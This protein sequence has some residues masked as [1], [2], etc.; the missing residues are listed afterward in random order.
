M[1]KST[2]GG[3]EKGA[4]RADMLKYLKSKKKVMNKIAKEEAPAGYTTTE[5]IIKAF[6]LKPKRQAVTQAKLTRINS[7]LDKNGVMYVSFN[8]VC[9]GNTGKGQTPGKYIGLEAKGNRTEEQAYKDLYFTL[10]KCGFD[11]DEL[12]DEEA[13]L[14]FI[15]EFNSTDSSEKPIVSITLKCYQGTKG[16][17]VDVQVNKLLEDFEPEDSEE[18]E[19]EEEEK[20]KK[21]KGKKPSK[22]EEEEEKDDDS[23]D[24]DEEEEE[25]EEEEKPAKK[26]KGKK[27]EEPEEEEDDVEYDDT[28]PSTWV[29]YECKAQPKGTTKKA[30]Y[31]IVEFIKRGSKLK[32][33]NSKDEEYIVASDSVEVL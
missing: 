13:L 9:V 12:G 2:K 7:G 5:D 31:E 24:D 1:K 25:D 8:F 3:S 18:E 4:S 19:E 27:K 21:G 32:L 20:P 6:G 11:T 26:G 10:Q 17:G 22:D 23:D 33:K 28:D 30:K 15:E 14:D 29:G 16:L